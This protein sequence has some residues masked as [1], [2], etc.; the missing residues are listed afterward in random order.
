VLRKFKGQSRYLLDT[1]HC[2]GHSEWSDAFILKLLDSLVDSDVLQYTTSELKNE[3]K[4]ADV[5][6]MIIEAL[7]FTDLTLAGVLKN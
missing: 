6:D 2:H 7:Q 5:W 4:L 1:S 3:G